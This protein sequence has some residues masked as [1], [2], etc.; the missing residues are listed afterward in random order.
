MKD[1]ESLIIYGSQ[2]GTTEQYGKELSR[3]TGIP[4]LDYKEVR[5]LE[6]Y[7]RIIYLGALYAGSVKGLKETLRGM[8]E[9]Q[10]LVLVTV[11][12]GDP[13]DAE[14]VETIRKSL[15]QQVP[16]TILN[17]AKLFHLRGGVDYEKMNFTHRTMMA[18]LYNKVKKLPEERQNAIVRAILDTYHK[19]VS[20]VD[21]ETLEPIAEAVQEKV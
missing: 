17:R 20:F 19:Q 14:S 3:R 1:M 12:L 5:H 7:D 13:A 18:L 16:E 6:G 9:S 21:F 11:G 15:A 2:Y 8:R 4:S 10:E